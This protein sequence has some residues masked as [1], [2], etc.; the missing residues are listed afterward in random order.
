[1]T[2]AHRERILAC[3]D[4]GLAQVPVGRRLVL[5]YEELIDDP[6]A[7]V[8]RVAELAGL[9]HSAAWSAE[10]GRLRYP[11]RSDAWRARMEPGA[12]ALVEAV[13]RDDLRRL[14]YL[15]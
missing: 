15:A 10:L 2:H 9:P 13:Q 12:A 3:I 11:N 5:R 6:L 14:G 1:V 8:Q 4:A 7:T